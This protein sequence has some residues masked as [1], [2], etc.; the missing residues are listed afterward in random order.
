MAKSVW[1][2]PVFTYATVKHKGKKKKIKV[3]RILTLSMEKNGRKVRGKL[4]K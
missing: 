3:E 1:K 4:L 2:I